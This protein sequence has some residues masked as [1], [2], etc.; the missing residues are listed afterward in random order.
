MRAF[1]PMLCAE[2]SKLRGVEEQSGLPSFQLAPIRYQA[3][4]GEM[5][6]RTPF[7]E[8]RK[9]PDRLW[10]S[11]RCQNCNSLTMSFCWVRYDMMFI[12]ASARGGHLRRVQS[13]VTRILFTVTHKPSRRSRSQSGIYLSNNSYQK[14]YTSFFECY[15]EHWNSSS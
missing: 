15:S 7:H 9:P 2:S 11:F 6:D 10:G 14:S 8:D 13:S 12:F 1:D 5:V 4:Q 3:R